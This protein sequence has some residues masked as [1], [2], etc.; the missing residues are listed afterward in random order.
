MALQT[1][2][3]GLE[4]GIGG[5]EANRSLGSAAE[6]RCARVEMSPGA[7]RGHELS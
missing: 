1:S 6:V 7:A 3:I 4:D 5:R 2:D